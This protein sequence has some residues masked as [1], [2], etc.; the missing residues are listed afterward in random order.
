MNR[1]EGRCLFGNDF[2]WTTVICQ[3][4]LLIVLVYWLIVDAVSRIFW[5]MVEIF[6]AVFPAIK[7]PD[8]G[9]SEV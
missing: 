4:A 3:A 8:D 2:G 5:R 1:N 6:R 9:D 7:D